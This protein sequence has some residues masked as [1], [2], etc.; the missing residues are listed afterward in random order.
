[1]LAQNCPVAFRKLLVSSLRAAAGVMAAAMV[2]VG[3]SR[4]GRIP[5]QESTKL[6]QIHPA[7][8]SL[9]IIFTDPAGGTIRNVKVTLRQDEKEFTAESNDEGW[10]FFSNL[11][12]G[13]YE[14]SATSPGFRTFHIDEVKAPYHAPIH[15]QMHIGELM[16]Q[17]VE[18]KEDYQPDLIHRLFSNLKHFFQS[19][20]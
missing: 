4:A 10:V 13:V 3:P 1:M 19:N 9:S 20:S 8:K 12:K 17:T 16:G 2:G 6:T 5:Q 7:S 15:L 14:L 11:P 18:V